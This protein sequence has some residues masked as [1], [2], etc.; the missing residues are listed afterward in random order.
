MGNPITT[1]AD[2]RLYAIA[3]CPQLAY[4]DFEAVEVQERQA[5]KESA[6]AV[7]EIRVLDERLVAMKEAAANTAAEEQR[8]SRLKVCSLH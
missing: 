6:M 5:I 4:V 2:Y 3:Y 1:E 8:I 7:D